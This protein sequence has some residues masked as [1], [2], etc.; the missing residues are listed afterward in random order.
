[1]DRYWEGVEDSGVR[2]ID[3]LGKRFA[4][5]RMGETLLFVSLTHE[6]MA[7]LRQVNEQRLEGPL[8]C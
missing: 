2:T 8:C 7:L 1:L 4:D 6:M 3:E 5:C